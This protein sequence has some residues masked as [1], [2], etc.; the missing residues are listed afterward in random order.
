MTIKVIYYKSLPNQFK[1]DQH[2]SSKLFKEE[3]IKVLELETLKV[4]SFLLSNN[5]KEEETSQIYD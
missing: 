4:C 1:I 5:K 3:I 2:C